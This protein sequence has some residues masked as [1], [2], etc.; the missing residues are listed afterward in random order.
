MQATITSKGQIT[1]L[2]ALRE[3]LHLEPGDKVE[4]VVDDNN[5]VRMLPRTA[6]VR[7]LNGMLPRPAHPVSLADMADAIT[8]AEDGL[9]A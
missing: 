3:R 9:P 4:F 1:L 7:R 5:G 2:K 6:S 8:A